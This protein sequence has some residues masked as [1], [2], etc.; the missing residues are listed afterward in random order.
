MTTIASRFLSLIVLMA[1]IAICGLMTFGAQRQLN[2]DHCLNGNG[3]LSSPC[4]V[5]GSPLW[6]YLE[7]S[8][9]NSSY[10]EGDGI[11]YRTKI[12]NLINGSWTIRFQYDFM[13]DGVV[14]IDRLT[15]SNLTQ[16][17]DA[18]A[19]NLACA[20]AFDF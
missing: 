3:E 9:D 13:R 5:S 17:S 14:A 4:S 16:V 8:S 20:P 6:D 19:A 1:T 18:C 2:L 7:A 15:R 10:R 12:S 11:P